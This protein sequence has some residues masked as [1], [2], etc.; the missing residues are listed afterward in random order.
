MASAILLAVALT[1]GYPSNID[2][3]RAYTM[4]RAAR[5]GY[6]LNERI[7]LY[8]LV[9][10][11]SNWNPYARNPNSTAYGLF[12]MLRLSPNTGAARQVER[13]LAYLES[14]YSASACRA[15]RHHRARGWY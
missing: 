5:E 13:G 7:C 9:K 15:W 14:R 4:H 11:E 12:Q 10:T 8:K 6:N 1:M 2:D 3:I